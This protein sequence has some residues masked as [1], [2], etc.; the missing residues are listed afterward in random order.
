MHNLS[1]EFTFLSGIYHFKPEEVFA[2][3]K[4]AILKCTMFN[5]LEYRCSYRLSNMSLLEFTKAEN[6]EH[7][8][9]SEKY[10]FDYNIIRYPWTPLDSDELLYCQNDV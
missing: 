5:K 1:Y 10:D 2:V 4:R 6:V 7:R 9:Y 8:K 3:D